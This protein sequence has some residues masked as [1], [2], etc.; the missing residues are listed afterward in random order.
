MQKIVLDE[1]DKAD[2]IGTCT[3]KYLSLNQTEHE[4]LECVK[5]LRLK[6]HDQPEIEELPEPDREERFRPQILRIT[7]G[8]SD[9]RGFNVV[10]GSTQVQ[11]N[12]VDLER[13]LF[14]SNP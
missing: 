11:G 2:D 1:W 13:G 14:R 6:T 5:R 8:G 9:F 12:F 10:S 4:L 7:Q 3:G